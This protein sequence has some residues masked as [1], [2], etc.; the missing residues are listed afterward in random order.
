[1][2]SSKVLT[3]KVCDRAHLCCV[4]VGAY[5]SHS[6]VRVLREQA[7][8]KHVTKYYASSKAVSIQYE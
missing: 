1:M 5:S 3:P 4:H 8:T 6:A 2:L 7:T